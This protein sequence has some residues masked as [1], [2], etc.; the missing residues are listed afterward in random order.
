MTIEESPSNSA[1]SD[2]TDPADRGTKDPSAEPGAWAKDRSQRQRILRGRAEW[3]VHEHAARSL[4]QPSLMSLEDTRAM[5]HELQVHQI[6][7]EMQNEELRRVQA[8]LDTERA[9]FRVL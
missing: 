1:D 4:D 6:E 7:L 3:A 8:A 9:L 5:L 2:L